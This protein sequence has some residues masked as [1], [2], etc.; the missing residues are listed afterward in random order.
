M[1]IKHT[2]G[3]QRTSGAAKRKL[4]LTSYT[5]GSNTRNTA[6]AE[7]LTRIHSNI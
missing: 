4:K 5:T 1:K 2:H 3:F 6:A 7:M